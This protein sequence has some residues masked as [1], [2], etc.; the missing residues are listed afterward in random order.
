M[1]GQQLFERSSTACNRCIAIDREMLG[2]QIS[3]ENRKVSLI[4]CSPMN[5][6]ATA[7][8]VLLRLS[9][10]ESLELQHQLQIAVAV[11]RACKHLADCSKFR[12]RLVFVLGCSGLFSQVLRL[13]TAG[14]NLTSSPIVVAIDQAE[15]ENIWRCLE[16]G[17]N[18]FLSQPWRPLDILPRAWRLLGESSLGPATPPEA[19][20]GNGWG[21]YRDVHEV[22]LRSGQSG[23]GIPFRC[24]SL[25]PRGKRDW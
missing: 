13:L 17:A 10:G 9:F 15:P 24:G 22:S 25:D 14:R 19:A 1:N 4:S 18:D 21:V 23:P 11:T 7:F 20:R 3:H 6:V 5:D 12:S 8:E 2:K 16:S